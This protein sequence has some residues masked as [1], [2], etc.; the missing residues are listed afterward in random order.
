[1]TDRYKDLAPTTMMVMM[2]H[3]GMDNIRNG[4]DNGG[5]QFF[6]DNYGI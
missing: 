3:D 4:V 1:M 5:L 6:N 2:N